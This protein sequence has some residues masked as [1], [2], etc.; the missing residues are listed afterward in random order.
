VLF[1]CISVFFTGCA[2]V[3]A[4]T[5]ADATNFSVIIGI[6]LV[7]IGAGVGG[8]IGA[9]WVAIMKGK[10]AAR[11]IDEESRKDSLL[12]QLQ[13]VNGNLEKV[14]KNEHATK[15]ELQNMR[16]EYHFLQ[17]TLH[18][19]NENFIRVSNELAEANA[20]NDELRH[21]LFG[22]KGAISQ[23]GRD[24]TRHHSETQQLVGETKQLIDETKQAMDR[25]SASASGAF[26]IGD[27][28]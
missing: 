27:T 25:A 1:K 26:P 17:E 3:A 22:L 19:A 24:E 16:L 18:T 2:I 23:I 4:A 12:A 10:V 14:R 9:A 7:G 5:I 20:K 6:I 11:K 13:E 15:Q 21:E 8:L 28:D